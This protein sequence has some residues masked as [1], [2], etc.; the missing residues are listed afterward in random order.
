MPW[1]QGRHSPSEPPGAP[2]FRKFW[3]E[4]DE[5]IKPSPVVSGGSHDPHSRNICRLYFS[6]GVESTEPEVGLTDFY[7]F[8][9]LFYYLFMRD[10]DRERG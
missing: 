3:M 4:T 8:R 9:F 5:Q 2:G 1:A 10:R 6:F 7:F